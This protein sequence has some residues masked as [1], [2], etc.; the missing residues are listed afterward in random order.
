MFANKTNYA[1]PS[2][3]VRGS[4]DALYE[5]IY[6][7]EPLTVIDPQIVAVNIPMDP[8]G[9][10][11]NQVAKKT[12]EKFSYRRELLKKW[13]LEIAFIAGFV[14]SLLI[15]VLK[16]T[17][18]NLIMTAAYLVI[19]LFRQVGFKSRAYGRIMSADKKPISFAVV[20]IFYQGL[21]Q[22]VHR[23]IAD[24]EGR[25]YTLVP[26]GKYD[27]AIERKIEEAPGVVKYEQVKK[28]SGYNAKNGVINLEVII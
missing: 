17:T 18:F 1:F 19:V 4:Y 20:R 16:P 27:I 13:S 24:V 23:A 14:I 21:A 15:Y 6:H 26:P 3:S 8:I 12:L 9:I 5:N 7:G 22:Q 11:W 2:K 28:L 10:D 25:Y